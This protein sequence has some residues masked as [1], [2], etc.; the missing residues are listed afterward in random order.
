MIEASVIVP[1]RDAEETLPR[2]LAALAEQDLGANAYEVIVVDDGSTDRTVEVAR[3]APGQVRVLEQDSQGPAQARN[4]GVAESLGRT[5]A[6]CDADVFPTPSW[7][8]AGMSAL[9][10]AD[11]V[12]GRVLPDP[13]AELG[14]FD[15]TLWV[16]SAVGLWETA[17]L[18]VTREAFDRA[19]G[20]EEWIKPELGKTLFEDSWFG[21]RA[22]RTGARASFCEEALAYH[23]VFARGWREY[24]DERRR[25]RYFP[26]AAA[27]MPELRQRFFFAHTFLS[28]RSAALDGALAGTLAALLFRSPVPLLACLP[29]GRMLLRRAGPLTSSVAAAD[30]AADVVGL[31][32]LA[33]GSVR[34]RSLLL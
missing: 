1:A 9:S 16:T 3:A 30:L 34:Y 13:Q 12:Q 29:Y 17:N 25:L 5:I 8:R 6:F 24:V 20:F 32:S 22:R 28:R 27:K 31:A 7:L 18:F 19:G 14:P 23:A 33:R 21:W 10:S 2:T 15:R 4:L 26:A 11:L